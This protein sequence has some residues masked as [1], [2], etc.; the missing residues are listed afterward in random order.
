MS[1]IP[2]YYIFPFG[3]DGT[4]TAVPT[5]T[6]GSGSVSYQSGWTINY[7]YNLTTNPAAFPMNRAQ[8]NQ[9]L[10]DVTS[11]IQQYWQYGTPNFITSTMNGGTP[12]AYP[13]FA[14]VYY[15]G[16]VYENQ[17]AGNVTTP[18][19]TGWNVISGDVEGVPTGTIIDFAGS[20]APTGYLLCDGSA[21]ARANY[22]NL[23]PTITFAQTGTLT[24][25]V[26]TVTGLTS[27]ATM[28][29][30]MPIEGTGVPTGTTVASIVSGTA[31]TMSQNAT[32]GG[33]QSLTF[34]PWG[35]GD[36]S[37]TFNVPDMR[38]R[39]T[40]GSGGT[41]AGATQ[42]P[43]VVVGNVGGEQVHTQ[44]TAEVGVH[45]HTLSFPSGDTS[46]VYNTSGSGQALSA[47]A[48]NLQLST[49]LPIVGNNQGSAT[50]FNVYHPV[51]V[52]NKIIKT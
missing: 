1:S 42:S 23:L 46:I 47:T 43:G 40:V 37:T 7:E 19:G 44:L 15:N 6:Q 41:G 10:Y 4:L 8:T 38:T 30:G 3:V 12:F 9:L 36:G 18:P 27:T 11:N 22:T 25:S 35:N 31:I 51:A 32:T 33:A 26:N 52:V 29:V 28:Y 39:S 45:A 34:F 20:T 24:N 17:V 48:A 5:D 13:I 2:Y 14:R 16:Q 21:V 50:P 49:T